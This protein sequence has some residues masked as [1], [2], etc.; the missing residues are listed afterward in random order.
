M[1]TAWTRHLKDDDEIA[2]FSKQIRNSVNVLDRLTEI[3]KED[4]EQL[5]TIENG[6][7][8]Y[9][10]PNWDNKQAHING[11]RSY[12]RKLLKLLDQGNTNDR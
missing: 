12:A 1:I 7:K 3:I 4:L 2:A 6:L 8:N 9:D 10:S 5:E 11:S